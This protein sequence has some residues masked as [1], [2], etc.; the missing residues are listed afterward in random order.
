MEENQKT[1]STSEGRLSYIRDGNIA[2]IWDA[3]ATNPKNGFFTSALLQLQRDGIKKIVINLQSNAMRKALDSLVKSGKISNPSNP[4]GISVDEH[5]STF[6]LGKSNDSV[7]KEDLEM[8]TVIDF[9]KNRFTEMSMTSRA[10]FF[11]TSEK[12]SL[13]I[14]CGM[15]HMDMIFNAAK[16][17]DSEHFIIPKSKSKKTYKQDK[18]SYQSDLDISDFIGDVEDA[19]K[20]VNVH[21]ATIHIISTKNH[22]LNTTLD[23]QRVRISINVYMDD[24]ITVSLQIRHAPALLDKKPREAIH[25]IDAFVNSMIK[26]QKLLMDTTFKPEDGEPLDE[27]STESQYKWW[28]KPDGIIIPTDGHSHGVW[29]ITYLTKEKNFNKDLVPKDHDVSTV[30][31]D[32][33]FDMGWVRMIFV[34]YREADVI[35]FEYKHNGQITPQQLKSLKDFAIERGAK[36]IHD[37]NLD[38]EE[39]LNESEAPLYYKRFSDDKK[40]E[41]AERYF[42]IG[43]DEDSEKNYCWIWDKATQSVDARKGHAHATHFGFGKKNYTFSGWYDVA[44][45]TISVVFPDSELRKLSG[46]APTEEDIPQQVY[47]KLINKFG[48]IKPKFVLFEELKPSLKNMVVEMIKDVIDENMTYKELLDLTTP[49]RKEKSANVRVRSIPV[50][51]ENGQQQWRFRY[52]SSPTTTVTNKPFEGH[53]TFFKED[54]GSK[55][56]AMDLDCKVDCGCPDYMY[57]F[58]Y[59][60]MKQD[61]GDIGRD[62]L[63]KCANRSPQPAYDIG[64][65]LCKHLAALRGYLQ[66]KIAATK[67]SNLFEALN[68]ISN[69][70]PFDITYPD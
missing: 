63:N 17:L 20:K 27:N 36:Y 5:P 19:L 50:S 47:Q 34:S 58:A 6:D 61:A 26:I 49:E 22:T 46:R 30:A 8:D 67:K 43:Q 31:T 45:N 33:L 57:K 15:L 55:E 44:K 16:M 29:A 28:M 60:N 4:I 32:M 3:R 52:K 1:I 7:L 12:D 70:G 13:Y 54:I 38:K 53:I 21:P 18:L 51:V 24:M 37:D 35:D 10:E 69:Q 14:S 2:R 64:E 40:Q 62:S 56:N 65:G 41:R 39:P 68:E 59:N 48:K 66:T 23:N 11:V 42:S 9:F 25:L